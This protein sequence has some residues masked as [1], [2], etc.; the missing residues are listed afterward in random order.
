MKQEEIERKYPVNKEYLFES[1]TVEL[2]RI[3]GISGYVEYIDRPIL[4]PVRYGYI[5]IF[6]LKPIDIKN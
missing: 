2:Q 1:E 3:E 5:T 4:H 6:Q